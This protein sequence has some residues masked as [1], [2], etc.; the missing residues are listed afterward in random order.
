MRRLLI[1][2]FWAS[3]LGGAGALAF[4]ATTGHFIGYVVA[5]TLVCVGVL[6]LA[7]MCWSDQVGKTGLLGLVVG[8]R[9]CSRPQD[10]DLLIDLRDLEVA[11]VFVLAGDLLAYLRGG[12]GSYADHGRRREWPDD[13]DL[14]LSWRA[15][16]KTAVSDA[17]QLND[18]EAAHARL[19]LLS[20]PGCMTVLA[21]GAG[22]R[23]LLPGLS[24][25][26]RGRAAHPGRR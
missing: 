9:A 10:R 8:R 4:A 13:A 12:A 20:S 2:G 3:V 25:V 24:P 16:R 14:F 7:E 23:L 21:D 6:A 15:P 17:C 19:R 1:F 22:N 11:G 18:W 26:E 5:G